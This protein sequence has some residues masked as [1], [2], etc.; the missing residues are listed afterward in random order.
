MNKEVLAWAA[1]L[2]DGEGCCYAANHQLPRLSMRQASDPEVLIRFH[3]AVGRLGSV[4]GPVHRKKEWSPVWTYSANRFEDAQ[5]VLCMIW[6][7]LSLVKRNQARR[8]FMAYLTNGKRRNRRLS[9]EDKVMPAART[10]PP[11]QA[12][13]ECLRGHPFTEDNVYWWRGERQCRECRKL[14][15]RVTD[16]SHVLTSQ[17]KWEA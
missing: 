2:F 6:P 14:R 12:K 1:G 8:V 3:E 10:S 13:T 15:Q 11:N 16:G 17:V 7:W 4:S 9:A 5:A